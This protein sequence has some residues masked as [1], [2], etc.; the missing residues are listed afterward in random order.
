VKGPFTGVGV[1][2]VT[3]FRDDGS[4][5][6]PA[7][8]ELAARLVGLG[9][10]GVVVAGSTGEAATLSGDE[11]VELLVAV[12]AAVGGAAPVIAGVGA[13]SARQAVA[14]ATDAVEHG[15]DGLLALS[16]PQSDDVRPYYDAV[17]KAAGGVPL[18]AYHF[19]AVS[20]PGIPVTALPA[21]PIDG[22]KDSSGDPGRFLQELEVLAPAVRLY[23]GSANLITYAA[24]LGA[25]GAIL[26]LANA[27]P[28]RCVRAWAGDATAQRELASG[29]RRAR[30]R[31]PGGLK[32]MVAARFGINP[33]SRMG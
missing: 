19:P 6:P 18:L 15:A 31:F 1:A 5:D 9:I 7:T 2:L 23:T 28:E 26:A 25:T 17:A 20:A 11:R 32:E 10:R 12:R 22:I 14:F 21:L 24:L 29:A 16:P 13:P 27:E 3:L 30:D 4:V 8:A 33:A